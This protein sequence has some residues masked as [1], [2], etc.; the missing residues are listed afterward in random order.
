MSL[1]DSFGVE[2]C[3]E[4]VVQTIHNMFLGQRLLTNATMEAI[5]TT[6]FT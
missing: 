3:R 2:A 6:R 1:Y 4:D 5:K